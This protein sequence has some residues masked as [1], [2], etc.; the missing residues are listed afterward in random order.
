MDAAASPTMLQRELTT[1][2]VSRRDLERIIKEE[3]ETVKAEQN[4]QL[5]EK[6]LV[7][8]AVPAVIMTALQNPAVQ[9][10]LKK[11]IM[12]LI[13]GTGKGAGATATT[14]DVTPAA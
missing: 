10:F 6:E 13:S 7:Q 1:M 5:Q 11:M 3:L 4:T 8:E 2:K 12:D 14:P 9:A